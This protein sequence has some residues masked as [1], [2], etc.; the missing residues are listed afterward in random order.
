MN[1]PRPSKI[2][3]TALFILQYNAKSI[4]Q[5]FAIE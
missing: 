1:R 5:L 4:G 2:A 3:G